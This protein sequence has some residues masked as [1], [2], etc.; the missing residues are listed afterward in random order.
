MRFKRPR[1]RYAETP[2]PSTPYQAAAQVWDER[3]GSARVQAKNWRLMAFGCLA[4]A[5]LMA[6]GLVW[7]SAQSIVTPYVVEV[8]RTGQVRAVGEAATPYR[9]ADAQVAYHLARFVTLVRSLS[10]DPIVVRQNW[11]E[12]YDYTTDRGAA[13]LNDYA[14]TNDPF[15]RVGKESVT[16]Q[17]SSLVRASDASFNV[18]WTERRFVNGA[19][20]GTERWNAVISIVLQ[21]PRTEQ[22]LR[23]NPLGI[24]VNGLSWSR[25]LDASEGAKP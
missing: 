11:L 7:R 16:V 5:L 1:V 21:T 10:I 13:A 6:G 18:R 25:E 20:A 17:V 24:Y 12:A 14:R 3:I 2:Q 15:V 22:R 19:P 9:P 23:K 8:D 4:L